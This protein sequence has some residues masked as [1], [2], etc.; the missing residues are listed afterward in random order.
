[1]KHAP[2]IGKL[3]AMQAVRS[4]KHFKEILRPHC[5][6]GLS[7]IDLDLGDTWSAVTEGNS[8]VSVTHKREIHHSLALAT[9]SIPF[10][11]PIINGHAK[12]KT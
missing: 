8:T 7:T 3:N 6:P 5:V 1:M 9:L 2:G 10:M 11:Q 12:T 4:S